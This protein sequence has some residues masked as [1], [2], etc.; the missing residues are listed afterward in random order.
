VTTQYEKVIVAEFVLVVILVAV[1]PF[2]R[3]QR[4]N[5]SPY[6]GQD[7]VQLVAIMAAYFI[8]GL[9]AQTGQSS[10]R[11][12]AW[13]GGLLALGIGLGEAAYLAKVFD[14]FGAIQAKTASSTDGE[15]QGPQD[16][17][18]APTQTGA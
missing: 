11:I 13:F 18:A 8:L 10:A 7:L 17:G 6:Y 2:T 9:V 5:L 16:V 14:L 4:D 15:S 12:A 1:A 3:K